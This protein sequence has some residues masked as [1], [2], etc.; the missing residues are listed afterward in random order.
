MFRTMFSRLA[1]MQALPSMPTEAPPEAKP[2]PAAFVVRPAPPLRFYALLTALF[3][4]GLLLRLW[5]ID[6]GLP[7]I[8]HPDES[9]KSTL[10]NMLQNGQ[11][12]NE[13]VN[14]LTHPGLMIN[15]VACLRRVLRPLAL[16]Q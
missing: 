10:I 13:E 2:Q 12:L 5:N 8:Y 11:E 7:M 14:A 4:A 6:F 16:P 1:C 3:V 9:K 15:L